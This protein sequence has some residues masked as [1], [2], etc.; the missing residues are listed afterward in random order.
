M[1]RK[2]MAGYPER[3]EPPAEGPDYRE[4]R[5]KNLVNR[6]I[7]REV[8]DAARELL[9]AVYLRGDT[10][11]PTRRM[12]EAL[13]DVPESGWGRMAKSYRPGVDEVRTAP[14]S[15][16]RPRPAVQRYLDFEG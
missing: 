11:K 15:R 12:E 16:T 7:Y 10:R 8:L 4:Y 13:R 3:G 6:R 14:A 2:D 9:N 5:R 1:N